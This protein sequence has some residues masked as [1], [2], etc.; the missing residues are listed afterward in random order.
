[1]VKF[2]NLASTFLVICSIWSTNIVY[3]EAFNNSINKV[4][5]QK[6]GTESGLSHGYITD[7]YQDSKGYI[8]IGTSDGLNRYDGK[9]VKR[10]NHDISDE[11]TLSSTYISAISEDKE[12]NIW[13][14]TD[15]GLNIL[16][17]DNDKMVRAKNFQ[18]KTKFL[19]DQNITSI[20][21]DSNDAMWIGTENGLNKY[22][23]DTKKLKT[24][25]TGEDKNK[26]LV[27]NYVTCIDEY[28]GKYILVGTKLGVSCID[29]ESDEIYNREKSQEDRL[30][31]YDIEVDKNKDIWISTKEGII[32]RTFDNPNREYFKVDIGEDIQTN[33]ESIMSDSNNNIWMSSSNG[34]IRYSIDNKQ[35]KLYKYKADDEKSLLSNYVSCFFEDTE[36]IIWIG[37]DRGLSI[38]NN[39]SQFEILGSQIEKDKER[40]DLLKGSI[41]WITQD[42][43]G[44][45]WIGTK[46][47][48]LYKIDNNMNT[49]KRYEYNQ[50]RKDSISSN[51]V[52]SI[53]EIEKGKMIISTDKGFDF[54]NE[55][56]SEITHNYFEGNYITEVNS[57]YKDNNII[58]QGT[59]SGLYSFDINTG[60]IKN[61]NNIFNELNISIPNINVI[62]E[63]PQDS[64][65]IWIGGSGNTGLIKFHKT[66]GIQNRYVSRDD[67]LNSLSY[68]DI[69]SIQGDKKGNLWIGTNVGLNKFNIKNETFKRYTVKDG[70]SNNYINGVLLDEDGNVWAST[71]NGLNKLYT[72]TDKFIKFTDMDGLQGMQYNKYS[73]YK[74]KDGLMFFGGTNGLTY[75]NPKNI[76]E[77]KTNKNNV[78][79]G[80]ILVNGEKVNY[81]GEE[82]VLNYKENNISF[83]YFLPN[84][85]NLNSIDYKYI[86]EGVDNDW[87]YS[88]SRNFANYTTLNPGKY[89][90]K[91]LATDGYGKTSKE[92][93]VKI[94]IKNPIWKTPIAY[95][96]YIIIFIAIIIYI[97]NYVKIL[98]K[99]VQQKTMH[100]NNQLEENEKLNKEIIDQEK[101]KNNY[102]VNLSHEL[103]TPINV[104]LSTV[105]LID[106]INKNM[107]I[108]REKS[109][110][111]M[112]IIR[113]SC[114]N[115]LKII[116]DIIDSSKIET[117]NY[118]IEKSNMDIVYIVEEAALT[119]SKYIESK[120]LNLIID[121]EIEEQIIF[122]DP[123]EIERCVINLLGNA[124]KFTPEGGEIRL[125]IKKVDNYIEISVEDTG[126]GI[127][128][129][130]QEFIFNR[131]SQV[132]GSGATK[133]S[134]SGIGL[135]LVK[136]IV[137]LHGGT[138]R[139][140]S[141]LNKGSKFT[142]SIPIDES[143][144]KESI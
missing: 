101:F 6:V 80:E 50:G 136:H 142:I 123:T 106:S 69:S 4:N 47:R 51:N 90:F 83:E 56:K 130:D 93:V 85:K 72:K 67:D 74:N 39:S 113:R 89:I 59:S 16:R 135:T 87:N 124:F 40:D 99:L 5:F 66:K 77:P 68:N 3:V 45:Y 129:E 12:G 44:E 141:E 108:S 65:I 70:L 105:Q 78:V 131:F 38:L 30:Y 109:S 15:N 32:K 98:E 91:V 42:S 95:T 76:S 122:C 81:T 33:I 84:Y 140:E 120:G 121:P 114:N 94:N 28:D 53:V 2:K 57:M 27:N 119:M 26:T 20:Y 7:I 125:Y 138:I 60:I 55:I 102:F 126:I 10:Y 139:L 115:L 137:E 13:I 29:I 63:D 54:I 64:N 118:K 88:K 46:Y 73:Y 58:W 23:I 112:K 62:Y 117:G 8:W 11:S 132:E 14:G 144:Q 22:N 24:Y 103:R 100:L 49:V 48:G 31:V 97:W 17:K 127:S 143:T 37:T 36:G 86:L 18:S 35:T 52:K 9:N 107:N 79:I 134:S 116:N 110:E 61:Y 104:I 71:N 41:T 133:A 19:T 82:I 21:R 96:L 34:A 92:T 25:K 75:F 128:K 1:M 111:Y 43:N